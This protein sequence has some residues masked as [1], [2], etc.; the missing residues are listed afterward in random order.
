SQRAELGDGEK[1]I[2]VGRQPKENH[3]PCVIERDAMRFKRA[4][5]G[6]PDRDHIG[7]LLRFGTSSAMHNATVGD[8]E[9]APEALRRKIGRELCRERS[10]LRP[11]EGK[12]AV[13]YGSSQRIKAKANSEHLRRDAALWSESNE[14]QRQVL[15]RGAEIKFDRDAAIEVT[16]P[17]PPRDPPR[18]CDAIAVCAN[19][20]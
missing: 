8:Q 19:S 5:I 11:R 7:E 10:E 4:Q 2:R 1:L 20:A 12:A 13:E 6:D 18:R 14:R 9:R 15:G 3:P 16:P 17:E